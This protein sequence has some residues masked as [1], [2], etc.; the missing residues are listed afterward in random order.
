MLDAPYVVFQGKRSAGYD[1]Q[2]WEEVK[3]KVKGVDSVYL[4]NAADGSVVG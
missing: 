3:R 4:R 2:R 1:G